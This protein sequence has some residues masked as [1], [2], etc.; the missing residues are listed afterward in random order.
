MPK[1]PKPS[2]R[3]ARN[4]WFVQVACKQ[5]NLGPDREAALRRYHELIGR[6][7]AALKPVAS[8]TVLGVLDAFL[9]W[10]QKHKAGR[11]Y[12]WYRGY[13]ESFARTL[14]LRASPRRS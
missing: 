1:F 4:A 10:C 14:C 5:I 6:S 7:K 12:D 3:T 8:D 11:T 9:E 13:L 2:F